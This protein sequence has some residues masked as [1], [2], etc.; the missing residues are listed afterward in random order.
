MAAVESRVGAGM[1]VDLPAQ[2]LVA[3]DG[4]RHAFDISASCKDRLVHGIDDIDTTLAHE[5]AI[6]RFEHARRAA[7]PWLPTSRRD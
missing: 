7:S 1:T 2:M 6:E 3:P 4:T 5:D